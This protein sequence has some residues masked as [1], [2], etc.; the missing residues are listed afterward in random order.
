MMA[1]NKGDIISKIVISHSVQYVVIEVSVPL[2][3]QQKQQPQEQMVQEEFIP[4]GPQCKLVPIEHF[5][6]AQQQLQ[7]HQILELQ[8]QIIVLQQQLQEISHERVKQV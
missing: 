3:L 7:Q 8:A 5:Q 1:D 2:Q 4:A 6:T